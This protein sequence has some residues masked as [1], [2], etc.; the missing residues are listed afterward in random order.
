MG[1]AVEELRMKDTDK[2]TA[3]QIKLPAPLCLAECAF[4]F[5]EKHA[6]FVCMVDGQER[7]AMF[8]VSLR[9]CS[10]P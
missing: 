4:P 2:L 6:S 8:V 10:M 9:S 7:I 5:P 3:G 1:R